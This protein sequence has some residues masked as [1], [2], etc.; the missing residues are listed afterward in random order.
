MKI[1]LSS[2]ALI[3]FFVLA[4]VAI[5]EEP[6]TGMEAT[7]APEPATDVPQASPASEADASCQTSPALPFVTG[8]MAEAA[9]ARCPYFQC[10]NSC[11]CPS[12]CVSNCV[13]IEWCEC[14]CD[15]P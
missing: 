12:G 14:V 1:W 7:V 6:S 11:S 15:C 8:P 10:V 2:L 3:T 13:S 5:A 4:G 9:P